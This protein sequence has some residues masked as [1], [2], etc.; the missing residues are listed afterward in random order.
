MGTYKYTDDYDYERSCPDIL[1]SRYSKEADYVVYK[2]IESNPY[3]FNITVPIS[4]AEEFEKNNHIIF[5]ENIRSYD[6]YFRKLQLNYFDIA[7]N[8][9]LEAAQ[10]YIFKKVKK[11]SSE[12]ESFS[13]EE[14]KS[15]CRQFYVDG[16]GIVRQKKRE[17]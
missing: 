15:L 16:K 10:K 1:V 3:D 7:I 12:D 14:L 9:S 13:F 5:P 11:S 8:D 4:K 6:S 2:N 17:Y